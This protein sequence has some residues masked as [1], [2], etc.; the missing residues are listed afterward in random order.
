M[1][2][3]PASTARAYVE[4]DDADVYFA[5]TVTGLVWA[6]Y[7][8]DQKQAALNQASDTIDDLN[9][10]GTASET[11]HEFPR[12]HQTEVPQRV[13]RACMEEALEILR[14][15]DAG[16]EA[17]LLRRKS[18]GIASVRSSFDTSM[19]VDH[20]RAGFVSRKAFDLIKGFLADPDEITL[21]RV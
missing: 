17:A 2:S 5:D 4:V 19:L 12:S 8:D 9:Y 11:N 6:N 1:S 18:H 21:D 13:L 3:D 7:T 14:G 15:A 16:A 20:V 10:A